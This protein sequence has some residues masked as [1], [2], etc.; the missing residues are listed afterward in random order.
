M[1]GACVVV[2]RLT[3]PPRVAGCAVGV[4]DFFRSTGLT[5]SGAARVREAGVPALGVALFFTT[6]VMQ[7]VRLLPSQHINALKW[8][9]SGFVHD[10]G[11]V[12]LAIIQ[13][14]AYR[15]IR[16]TNSNDRRKMMFT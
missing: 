12:R 8:G 5:A 1:P 11:T 6:T 16:A 13:L 2:G 4:C 7:V 3:G 15:C 14:R 9:L 10:G